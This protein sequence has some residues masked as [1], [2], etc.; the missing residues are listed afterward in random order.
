MKA[1]QERLRQLRAERRMESRSHTK[2]I[3]GGRF[4]EERQLHCVLRTNLERKRT[5]R[6]SEELLQSLD[7]R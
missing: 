7:A 5:L 4:L 3:I 2:R 6:G 1:G